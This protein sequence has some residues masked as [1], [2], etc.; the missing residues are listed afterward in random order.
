MTGIQWNGRVM[1][2]AV[3]NSLASYRLSELRLKP[4]LSL[5]QRCHWQLPLADSRSYGSSTPASDMG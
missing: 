3:G 4:S 1:S 2:R 5:R